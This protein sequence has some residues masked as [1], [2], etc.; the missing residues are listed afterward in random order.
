ME[1]NGYVGLGTRSQ[2]LIPEY[3]NSAMCYLDI[4]TNSF[5]RPA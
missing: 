2:Y 1:I 3:Q 5:Y 4:L